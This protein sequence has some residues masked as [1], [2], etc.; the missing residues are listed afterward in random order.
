MA[1]LSEL[2]RGRIAIQCDVCI[3]PV[4]TINTPTQL[5]SSGWLLAGD[6]HDFDVCQLCAPRQRT[7][8]RRGDAEPAEPDPGRLPNLV[9]IGA[10][11]AGTTSLF[12]YLA[13]HPQIA[14]A[15][16]KEVRF[17]Q[18][19]EHRRWLGEYQSQFSPG[20]RY[21]M[22]ASPHYTKVPC[23]PGA[24]DRIAE[25]VP[26]ARLV[27][28]VRDPVERIVAEYVEQLQWRSTTGTLEEELANAED[29]RNW[30]VAASRYATQL[31][32]YRRR[33]PAEQIKVVDLDVLA[34]R[35][36]ETLAEIYEFLGLDPDVAVSVEGS[37][38]N[39]RDEKAAFHPWLI[40]L[41]RGPIVRAYHRLPE[42]P[43]ESLR[44]LIW[45]LRTPVAAPAL[46][47]ATAERLREVLQPEID[48]LRRMTGLPFAGWSL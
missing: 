43:K 26:D 6:G 35:H 46:A 36:T 44:R 33:F 37:R 25:L 38:H 30:I 32:E 7:H 13:H 12:N 18:D 9:I 42:R 24:A 15:R 5:R 47:P 21:R 23:M 16:D 2:E 11:K 28:L 22:E 45:R 41:R 3:P 27:Y 34:A 48:D 19:P 17:F 4:V 31:R 10:M 29:P 8:V 14:Q 20:T 39:T 1:V 40:T